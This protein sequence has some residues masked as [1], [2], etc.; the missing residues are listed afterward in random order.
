[1]KAAGLEYVSAG[2]EGPPIIC[3]H[4]IGGGA[5]SFAPQLA[6]LSDTHHV[7]A[8][9]LPGYGASDPL[10]KVTFEALA[11]RIVGFLDA[12]GFAQAHLCGQSIGG[13]IAIEA[14]CH[15]PE[16][17]ASLAL[18]A[19]TSAF[20]GRDDTFRDQFLAARLA[21]LDRGATL[22]DLAPG[23]VPEIMGHTAMPEAV[24]AAVATMSAVPEPTYRDII[25]C[26]VTFDRRSDVA[27]LP[28]PA[29][30]IAGEEDRN[31][32]ARTMARMAQTMQA[33]FHEIAG[34]GHLVNLEA[35]SATNDILRAFYRRV[36]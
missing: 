16:R 31:A 18:I 15:W 36:S 17:V 25:R 14:A 21:P 11:A 3:L 6:G 34:V 12:K 8:V 29:C 2:G 27:H 1:M 5:A 7:I 35:A 20:G 10:Q 28:M 24:A 19:T 32:P 9:D 26:L 4:G 13:M 22:A 23:F 33:E 30:L